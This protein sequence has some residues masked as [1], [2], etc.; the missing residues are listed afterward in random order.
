MRIQLL[1]LP[2]NAESVT[3]VVLVISEV[4]Q[5]MVDRLRG[6]VDNPPKWS[7]GVLVLAGPVDVGDDL[8]T[9]AE[10]RW[11]LDLRIPVLARSCRVGHP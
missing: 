1:E 9:Y 8:T 5:D 4:P 6:F 3:P 11:E 10:G 7:A 2:L